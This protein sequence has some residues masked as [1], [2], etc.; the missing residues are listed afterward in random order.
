VTVTMPAR[1]VGGLLRESFF[2]AD[3]ATAAA[4]RPPQEA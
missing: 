2:P 1:G 4:L 3:A